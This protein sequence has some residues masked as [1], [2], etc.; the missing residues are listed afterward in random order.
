MLESIFS[1]ND[2]F[3]QGRTAFVDGFFFQIE[4]CLDELFFVEDT[5]RYGKPFFFGLCFKGNLVDRR[6][7]NEKRSKASEVYDEQDYA[8]I[9]HTAARSHTESLNFAEWRPQRR[10]YSHIHL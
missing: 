3:L 7:K 10:T 5:I 6:I 9:R 8:E 1:G 2:I 4:Q